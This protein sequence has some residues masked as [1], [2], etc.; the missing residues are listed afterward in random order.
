MFLDLTAA[1]KESAGERRRSFAEKFSAARKTRRLRGDCW[2]SASTCPLVDRVLA[3][4]LH[5]LSETQTPPLPVL[6]S[7]S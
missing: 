3:E 6:D 7:Q 2:P 4:G 5:R 1:A